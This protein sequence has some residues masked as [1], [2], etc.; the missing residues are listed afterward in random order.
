MELKKCMKIIKKNDCLGI[1]VIH[2]FLNVIFK[3]KLSTRIK[4]EKH[5]VTYSNMGNFMKMSISL[6]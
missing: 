6:L 1:L 5:S 3:K 4:F 2:T